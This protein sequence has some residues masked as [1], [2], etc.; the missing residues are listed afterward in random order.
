MPQRYVV[1]IGAVPRKNIN[2]AAQALKLFDKKIDLFVMGRP[3]GVGLQDCRNVSFLGYIP[4][5]DQPAILA[6]AQL[7]LYPSLY[8][9]F[10]L[11][12]LEAMAVGCPVVTSNISS[13]PEVAGRSAILVDPFEVDNISSGISTMM[14]ER[15]K[16]IKLGKEQAK[17]FSWGKM[18][19]ETDALYRHLV[20]H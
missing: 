7:L 10:G 9:G 11:P 8:E 2:R 12:I 20:P 18:A 6:G 15:E 16:Y 19:L 17:K 14:S 3:W 4:R 13:M 1:G 5:G